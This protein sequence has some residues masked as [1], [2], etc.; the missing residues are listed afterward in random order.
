MTVKYSDGR[1]IEGILLTMGDSGMRVAL[2]GSEDA[3]DFAF[4]AGTWVSENCEPVGI[5]FAWEQQ[6]PKEAV[7]EADC[8]CSKELAARLLHLLL[9]GGEAN[10]LTMGIIP[11]ARTTHQ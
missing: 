10:P 2:K 3:V 11:L 5:E 4:M 6:K 1:R 8:I 9:S 7:S